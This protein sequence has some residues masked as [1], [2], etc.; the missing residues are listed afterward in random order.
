MKRCRFA[1]GFPPCKRGPGLTSPAGTP[2][3]FFRSLALLDYRK[4]GCLLM[5]TWSTDYF[6]NE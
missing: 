5:R 1:E 3:D 6:F 4:G 2:R